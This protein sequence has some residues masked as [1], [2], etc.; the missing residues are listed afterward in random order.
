MKHILTASL[1]ALII[2][3]APLGA[4][5]PAM[6]CGAGGSAK[7]EQTTTKKAAAKTATKK[8]DD[9]AVAKADCKDGSGKDCAPK[10]K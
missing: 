10:N 6:A 4:V 9:R 3:L 1:F 5:T 7:M 2:G 8:A